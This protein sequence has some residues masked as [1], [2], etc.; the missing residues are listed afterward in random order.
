M[1][2]YQLRTAIVALAC[3]TS[4]GPAL[5]RTLRPPLQHPHRKHRRRPLIIRPCW[6]CCAGSASW[7]AKW[8]DAR[9]TRI[10]RIRSREQCKGM[11]RCLLKFARQA[12]LFGRLCGLGLLFKA[13]GAG[14]FGLMGG[15]CAAQD[16]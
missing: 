6:T 12:S 4:A 15:P 10:H 9:P 16:R 3:L 1:R 7:R 13:R 14:V 2:S 5:A 8:S 11:S